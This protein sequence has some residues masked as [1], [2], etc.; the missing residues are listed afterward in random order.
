MKR[1]RIIML[2]LWS[3]CT[4]VWAQT[5]FEYTRAADL[6]EGIYLN[7]QQYITNAPIPFDSLAEEDFAKYWDSKSIDIHN[8]YTIHYN[9]K[10]VEIP[11]T[12][13]FGYNN[14]NLFF[15]V[16]DQGFTR[17]G[18]MGSL[19]HFSMMVTVRQPMPVATYGSGMAMGYNNSTVKL[20]QFF[21]DAQTGNI[22]E[23]T[24]E[25]LERVISR[26]SILY[27]EFKVAFKRRNK[28]E[29][30]M[31]QFFRAYNAKYPLMFLGEKQED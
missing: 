19:T 14:G 5:T 24:P 23:F 21:L 26:D 8:S 6:N 11:S 18:I 28:L 1:V 4:K 13:F 3:L 17:A 2:L 27:E 7:F 15:R 22:Y 30:K 9:G 31:W 10:L 16:Y 12:S 20:M 25:N 29:E